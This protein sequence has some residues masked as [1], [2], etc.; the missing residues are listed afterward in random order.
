MGNSEIL[1]FW[2]NILR[3]LDGVAKGAK[4]LSPQAGYV[5]VL[6]I[7]HVA[8]IR[9]YLPKKLIAVYTFIVVLM[10]MSFV[11]RGPQNHDFL[12]DIFKNVCLWRTLS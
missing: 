5:A 10:G 11:V 7:S 6:I 1:K 4:P 8:Q 2:P 3:G 12:C 9:K